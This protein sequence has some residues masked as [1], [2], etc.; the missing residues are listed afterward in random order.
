MYSGAGFPGWV[1]LGQG[2]GTVLDNIDLLG[3]SNVNNL[4]AIDRIVLVG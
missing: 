2:Q 1:G 3:L 4:I